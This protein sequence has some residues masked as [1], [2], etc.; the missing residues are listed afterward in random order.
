MVSQFAYPAMSPRLLIR[1]GEE[2]LTKSWF[3]T[4]MQTTQSI[5]TTHPTSEENL[6]G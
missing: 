4:K 5:S 3:T 2:K 6:D 1:W